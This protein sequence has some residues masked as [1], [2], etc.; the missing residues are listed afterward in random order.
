MG[1]ETFRDEN[2]TKIKCKKSPMNSSPQIIMCNQTDSYVL[3]TVFKTQN[4]SH[5]QNSTIYICANDI[6]T[7]NKVSF[8][9]TDKK[10]NK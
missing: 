10:L 3:T 4:S 9:E 2:Y 6:D 1:L 5:S 7:K 8:R